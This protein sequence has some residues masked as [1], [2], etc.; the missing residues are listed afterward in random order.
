MEAKRYSAYEKANIEAHFKEFKRCKE[1]WHILDENI[2]N[3]DE[4]GYMI[5]KVDRS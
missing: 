1:H 3:F 5:S 4:T 2:Y